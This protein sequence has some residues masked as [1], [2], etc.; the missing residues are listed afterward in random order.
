MH[1]YFNGRVWGVVLDFFFIRCSFC[2]RATICFGLPFS[3]PEES[4]LIGETRWHDFLALLLRLREHVT[5]ETTARRLVKAADFGIAS[6]QK[7][8]GNQTLVVSTIK[9]LASV[10]KAHCAFANSVGLVNPWLPRRQ[11]D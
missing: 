1:V 7:L 9:E 11:F 6:V 10:G 4:S 5:S 8:H 2:L 3:S